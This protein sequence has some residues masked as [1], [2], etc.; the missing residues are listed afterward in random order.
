M[1]K[2]ILL[3]ALVLLLAA[4]QALA[5]TLTVGG[6]GTVSVKADGASVTLGVRASGT[7]VVETQ[8]DV[9]ERINAMTEAFKSL[10]I[11][12]DSIAT[13]MLNIYPYTNENDE[14]AG[15]SVANSLTVTTKDIDEVGVIIDAAIEAGANTM[16]LSG[17]TA[18]GSDEAYQEA[19]SLAVKDA[20]EK[21]QVIA[22]AAGLTVTGI[23]SVDETAY[24]YSGAPYKRAMGAMEE[25]YS[26]AGTQLHAAALEVSASVTVIFDVE[27]V[28]E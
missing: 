13:D 9:N 25:S 22:D 28:E 19:L 26:D 17:Y 7:D 2:R 24:S 27:P 8:R 6:N 12:D 10:G 5:A 11:P 23:Q 4:Q 20:M 21:A 1:I 14:I 18:S 15:Y 3:A 16:Q